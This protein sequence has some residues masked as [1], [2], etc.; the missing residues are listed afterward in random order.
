MRVL[1]VIPSI[2]AVYGGPSQVVIEMCQTLIQKGIDVNIVTTNADGNNKLDIPIHQWVE[3]R[4]VQTYIFTSAL[5]ESIK[6]ASGFRHWLAAEMV[7]YDF[8]H[9][10][11]VFSYTCIVAAS[12]CRKAQIKYVMR[13]LGTLDPWSMAQKAFKKNLC[14]TL[15]LK[16]LLK[17]ANAIQYTTQAEMDR[18]QST[19]GLNNG[20][21]IANGLFPEVYRPDPD[22]QNEPDSAQDY[23]LY[24]GRIA[25]KKNIET[26]LSSFSELKSNPRFEN[27]KLLIAGN[28][29]SDY[30]ESIASLVDGHGN[31]SDI[32]MLG[33]ISGDE[34]LKLIRQALLFVLPSSNENYGVVVAECAAASVPVVISDQ[35]FLSEEI[36]R[37]N[38]GWIWDFKSPL[39]DTL[40]EA[41]DSSEL[42]ERGENGRQM[43]EKK[44][45]W[46]V[47]GDQLCD[48]YQSQLEAEGD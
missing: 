46:H 31:S 44:Y 20:M 48:Y 12:V 18:T 22:D 29:D 32:E 2:A 11:A 24:F 8:V 16:R 5:G 23:I 42:K 28:G 9:I 27:L 41:L 19:L 13:P 34:K 47:L 7:N 6:F 38:A 17:A 43:V 39:I 1:H 37:S 4:G 33:W 36:E 15:G 25:P 14:L 30:V 3:Y 10:H 45:D 21:V 35:V 40:V 26:L